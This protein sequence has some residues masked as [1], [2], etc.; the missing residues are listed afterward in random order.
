MKIIRFK[1]NIRCGSIRHRIDIISAII[2]ACEM[3]IT[4]QFSSLI[5]ETYLEQE[6]YPFILIDN[7]SRLFIFEDNKFFSVAFPF[8]INTEKNQISFLSIPISL[9]VLSIITSVF[10]DFDERKSIVYFTETIL[11]NEEYKYLPNEECQTIEEL[12][13]YLLSYEIGYI[14]YDN[15]PKNFEKYRLLGK[16]NLH[17]QN[18]LDINY[19]SNATFK[20]GLNSSINIRQFWDCINSDTDCWFVK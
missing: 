9:G 4:N 16:P 14:R 11:N 2:T 7:T 5:D 12:V 1:R 13:A 6:N 8:Q 20:L 15:D 18:H 10:S 3:I 19:S 17:P